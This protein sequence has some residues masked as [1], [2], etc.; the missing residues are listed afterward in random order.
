M[1]IGLTELEYAVVLD[2]QDR[3]AT[4]VFARLVSRL[5]IPNND[6][7]FSSCGSDSSL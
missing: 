7:G 2:D 3:R 4:L 6:Q 5:L 1:R